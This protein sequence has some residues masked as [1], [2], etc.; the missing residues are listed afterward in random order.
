MKAAVLKEPNK[1]VIEELPVPEPEK[2]WALVK[3]RACGVCGS[4]LRYF[5]GENPW[6]VHTLGYNKPNPPNIIIGHEFAGEIV[7]VGGTEHEDMVGKRVAVLPYQN[8]NE[9]LDC[10]MG[11]H[12]LCEKMIHLGHAAGWDEMD[13][14]PGGM[15]EYCAVWI[16][17]CFELPDTVTYEQAACID[18]VGVG[19]HSLKQGGNLFDK[20]VAVIGCGPIGNS[21][22]QLARSMGASKVIAIDV[23]EKALDILRGLG[24]SDVYENHGA[25]AGKILESTENLGADVVWDTVGSEQTVALGFKILAKKGTLVYVATHD[26]EVAVNLKDIGSERVIRS[27]TNY[28]IEDFPETISL[29]KNKKIDLG[30]FTIN[31]YNID[32][33][34]EVFDLL[35]DK[36]KSQIL[37]AIII[38]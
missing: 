2:G 8:C 29:V 25:I 35:L 27:S 22:C 21:I 18:F 33:V 12:H 19:Y 26:M 38:P 34:A 9:C 31:T 37:K 13:Y 1:L 36:T 5:V 24:F 28:R 6:A 30:P 4:D 7:K 10:K 17:R 15:A 20:T 32:E 11:N 16:D 14:Y 3:V 23:Y